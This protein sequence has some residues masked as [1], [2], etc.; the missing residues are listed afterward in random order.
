VNRIPTFCAIGALAIA[1]GALG[2]VVAALRRVPR[3]H[4]PQ[5]RPQSPNAA[6]T[7]QS[8][9]TPSL[10]IA[11]YKTPEDGT[12]ISGENNR[13]LYVLTADEKS[14]S[15]HEK[16]STCYTGCAAVWP[17]VLASGTPAV[18]GKA[19]ASMLGLTTRRD[20]TKQ[21]T[22]NGLPLYYYAADTKP[23]QATGNHLKDSFGLWIGMLPSGKLAPDGAS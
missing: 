10:T 3:R 17:P 8:A 11:T 12:L 18:A 1:G 22:Y 5:R 7:A 23:G 6:T 14:T 19:N 20:G 4:R 15:A 13:T 16:L 21:V 9:T 2:V